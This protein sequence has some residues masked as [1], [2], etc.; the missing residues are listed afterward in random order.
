[1]KLIYQTQADICR[2]DE[3]GVFKEDR[4]VKSILRQ[5]DMPSSFP[6]QRDWQNYFHLVKQVHKSF[7]FQITVIESA[8]RLINQCNLPDLHLLKHDN[9]I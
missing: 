4:H 9:D 5:K 8:K 6:A 1:M 2:A 3:E 7:T